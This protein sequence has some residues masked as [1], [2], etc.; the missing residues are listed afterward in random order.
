[1]GISL[2]PRSSTIDLIPANVLAARSQYQVNPK[3]TVL[4]TTDSAVS[5]RFSGFFPVIFQRD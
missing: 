3:G 5:R 2:S 4:T 1:M